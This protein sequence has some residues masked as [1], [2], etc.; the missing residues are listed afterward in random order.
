MYFID[1]VN[2]VGNKIGSR[3]VDAYG[4][5][6]K[7]EQRIMWSIWSDNSGEI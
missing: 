6:R 7:R 2:Y 5:N 3:P 1:L 4:E